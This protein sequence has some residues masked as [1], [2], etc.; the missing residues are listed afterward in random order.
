MKF[1]Y[2][3]FWHRTKSTTEKLHKTKQKAMHKAQGRDSFD[4]QEGF[5]IS[6]VLKYVTTNMM[7]QT[8]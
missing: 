3:K 4:I 7:P 2:W 8:L 6:M 5:C 1:I